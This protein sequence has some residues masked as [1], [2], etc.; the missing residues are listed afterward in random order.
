MNPLYCSAII[1]LHFATKSVK[2]NIIFEY[3]LINFLQKF[4]NPQKNYTCL[5]MINVSQV[6]ITRTFLV[7]KYFQ[8]LFHIY[9]ILLLILRVN[10]NIIKIINTCLVQE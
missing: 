4:A 3:D 6:I 8:D 1:N 2:N 10:K 7:H 9:N 5:I